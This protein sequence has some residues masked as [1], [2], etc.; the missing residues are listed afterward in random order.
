M[1]EQQWLSSSD[2]AAMLEWLCRWPAT[3]E[4][5]RR[6]YSDRKMRLFAVACLR[7]IGLTDVDCLEESDPGLRPGSEVQ[8]TDSAW[9]RHWARPAFNP[10][11]QAQKVALVRDIFGNPWQP[12]AFGCPDCLSVVDVT[13]EACPSCG[14]DLDCGAF[15]HWQDGTVVRLARAAYDGNDWGSMGILADAL[16]EAGCQNT[17]ILGHCRGKHMCP[18]CHG[19]GVR[20]E[21][22]PKE[23]PAGVRVMVPTGHWREWECACQ[24]LPLNLPPATHVRGCCVLDFLLGKG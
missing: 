13:D 15:L 12:F 1:T 18:L 7:L 11:S 17:A 9:A 2:P 19:S 8:T 4:P 22:V 6:A 16:E 14:R 24:S 20:R 5:A 3:P 23:Y 10:P 21:W